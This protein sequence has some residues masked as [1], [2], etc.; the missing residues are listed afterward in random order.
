M[1]RKPLDEITEE[2]IR[3]LEAG[4]SLE[5]VLSLHPEETGELQPR[6][7]VWASL[8][9]TAIPEALA[10]GRERSRRRLMEALAAAPQTQGGRTAMQDLTRIGNNALRWAGVAAIVAA[11]VLS[12]AAIS[13]NLSVSFGGGSA[14]AVPGDIDNDGVPDQQDNCPIHPNPDQADT[15]GDGIGDVCDP[16]PSGGLPPCVGILDFNNDGKLDVNDV[17][18]FRDAFGSSSG[19]PNYDPVVDI[20]GDGDVDIFDVSAAV[21]QIVDCLRQ[22]QP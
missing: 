17:M 5:H 11:A 1:N 21:T 2:C 9:S 20:D 14:Q 12:L 16:N 7:E 13:G 3:R 10:S 22:S 8:A 19:D 4:A 6:L 18:I 15:D